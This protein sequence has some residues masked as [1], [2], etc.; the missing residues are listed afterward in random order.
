M[1]GAIVG[2]FIAAWLSCTAS[3]MAGL[4]WGTTFGR[5]LDAALIGLLAGGAL[6]LLA[7]YG[8]PLLRAEPGAGREAT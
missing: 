2:A 4:A 3:L 5:G 6:H 7:T 1:S 8:L